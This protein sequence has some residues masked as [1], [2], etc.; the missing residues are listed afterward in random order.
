MDVGALLA[1][2]IDDYAKSKVPTYPTKYL[3]KTVKT[4]KKH[5][6]RMLHYFPF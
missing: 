5:L 1:V 6:G 4:G 2:Q 3:Q